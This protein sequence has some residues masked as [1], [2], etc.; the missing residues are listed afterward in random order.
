MAQGK[1]ALLLLGGFTREGPNAASSED[2]AGTPETITSFCYVYSNIL[3]DIRLW[4]GPRIE[5]FLSA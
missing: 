2:E 3:G 5:N 1:D 4:V